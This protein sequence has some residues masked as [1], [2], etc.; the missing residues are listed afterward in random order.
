M[1]HLNLKNLLLLISILTILSC[2]DKDDITDNSIVW[3]NDK[4]GIFTDSRDNQTYK[5]VKIGNQ[6]LFAE[7]LKYQ[8]SGKEITDKTEW[9]NNYDYDGWSFYD[10]S[11]NIGESYGILY[12][13]EAAKSACPNGWHLMTDSEWN[14]LINYL[15]DENNTI[16]GNEYIALGKL[17]ETGTE[18]W[19]GTNDKVTNESGFSALGGGYRD[20]NGDS[21]SFRIAGHFWS[22]TTYTRYNE[23]TQA[24]R[25]SMAYT[26]GNILSTYSGKRNGLSARCVKN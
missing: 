13:W 20:T 16:I 5:V 7:N 12:Q 11:L 17:K 10:N 1:K 9:K 22:S 4:N 19:Y 14:E 8:I 18:Y 2:Q 26:D 21:R 15:G 23:D 6:I 3:K 25:R 24:Y